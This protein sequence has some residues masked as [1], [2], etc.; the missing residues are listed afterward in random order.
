MSKTKEI[1]SGI[2]MNDVLNEVV[3]SLVE[4]FTT[5]VGLY[6]IH[7]H[8]NNPDLRSGCRKSQYFDTHDS[9]KGVLVRA[10]WQ[11]DRGNLNRWSE[12]KT[13]MMP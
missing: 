3:S 9:G 4:L 10:Y 1:M 6:C 7:P 8:C 13:A 12:S 5:A 11:N 2:L